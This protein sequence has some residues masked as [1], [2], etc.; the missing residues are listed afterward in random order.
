MGHKQAPTPGQLAHAP[1]GCASR[2]STSVTGVTCRALTNSEHQTILFLIRCPRAHANTAKPAVHKVCVFWVRSVHAIL[3]GRPHVQ[4][5]ARHLPAPLLELSG[6]ISCC[7]GQDVGNTTCPRYGPW[8][9]CNL[10]APMRRTIV[11]LMVRLDALTFGLRIVGVE[12]CAITP[13]NCTPG[14][15]KT[16]YCEA[17]RRHVP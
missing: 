10:T 13:C 11:N 14:G 9:W 2:N 1:R 8:S 16:M 15:N 4:A 7:S 3:S 5:S 6:G 12:I 17:S